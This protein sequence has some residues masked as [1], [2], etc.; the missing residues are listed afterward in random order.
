MDKPVVA[1]F[2][3][4]GTITQ[5]DTLP[6]FITHA[7]GRMGFYLS[8]LS[9]LPAM[10]VLACSHWKSVW[11]IDAGTTKERL[12]RRSFAGR[13]V[14]EVATVA[15]SFIPKI[16][17]VL[18]PEVIERLKWH[19][20]QGHKVV[21]VSA[22]IDVWVGA[23]AEAHDIDDV[24]ATQ[25]EVENGHYTGKFS[26]KNCNGNEKVDFIARRFPKDDYHLVA[27]GN[28]SGDYPM[29]HYAHQAYLCINGSITTYK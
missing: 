21:I 13:S 19:K 12:L 23:W 25:L 4:D 7:T 8:M 10:I 18:A 9:T 20:S 27:Y 29:F 3:F 15:R 28:S 24:I 14:E 1:L 6:T 11:G 17:A 5:S 26:G 2:D 22:S 16:D